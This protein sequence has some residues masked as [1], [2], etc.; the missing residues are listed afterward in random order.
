MVHQDV[1]HDLRGEREELKSVFPIAFAMSGQTE[2]R[3]V[4]ESGRLQ[5]MA[6]PLAPEIISRLPVKLVVN[7]RKQFVKSLLVT[8]APVFQ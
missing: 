6:R 3:L 2:I 7:K 4:Q 1:A 8:A 5:R